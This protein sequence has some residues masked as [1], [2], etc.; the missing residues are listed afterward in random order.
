MRRS[1]RHV[2]FLAVGACGL[3]LGCEHSRG[4]HYPPDPLL[5]G[6]KPVASKPGTASAP[7]VA[8]REPPAPEDLA[9]VLASVPPEETK[10]REPIP[11]MPASL[12]RDDKDW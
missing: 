11:A 3:L 4:S 8:L 2:G 10:Q 5:L 6:R 1:L 12:Q 7:A 9:T